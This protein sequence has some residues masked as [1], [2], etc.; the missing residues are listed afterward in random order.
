MSFSA[1]VD[2][3]RRSLATLY[4][5]R[6]DV[7]LVDIAFCWVFGA[8]RFQSRISSLD[9]NF[10][11]ALAT[12]ASFRSSVSLIPN[13]RFGC[14]PLS[15]DVNCASEGLWARFRWQ[16][17]CATFST[18]LPSAAGYRAIRSTLPA[19]TG[20]RSCHRQD[21]ALVFVH[22][23]SRKRNV[24]ISG[25]R[26]WVSHW[27]MRRVAQSRPFP[28]CRNPSESGHNCPWGFLDYLA[29][30]TSRAF[31]SRRCIMPLIT[32]WLSGWSSATSTRRQL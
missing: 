11:S 9:G 13:S 22:D 25:R 17:L 12:S 28:A 10:A 29:V 15:V 16:L 5:Q 30:P 20:V 7:A 31:T 26:F 27:R 32:F 8:E 23:V 1:V 14:W 2:E 4:L 19:L 18:R 3:V 24:G 6:P 21:C